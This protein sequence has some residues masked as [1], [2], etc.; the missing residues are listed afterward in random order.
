MSDYLKKLSLIILALIFTT[1]CI[2]FLMWG[3]SQSNNTQDTVNNVL[4]KQVTEKQLKQLTEDNFNNMYDKYNSINR[5]LQDYQYSTGKRIE[6]LESRVG[7]LEN[8]IS[9]SN[10]VNIT[11]NN[12]GNSLSTIQQ[13]ESDK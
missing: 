9:N 12:S 2:Y 5:D 3:Y 6:S 11:N 13:R 8:Q 4:W 7:R 1:L 10:P